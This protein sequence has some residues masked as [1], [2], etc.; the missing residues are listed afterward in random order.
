ML[1]LRHSRPVLLAAVL[2]L[3]ACGSKD[4]DH[5]PLA[6][7]PADTPFV[8][9]NSAA[10]PDATIDAW[11]RQ[12]QGMWPV[13]IGM[14]EK[15][16]DDLA[17]GDAPEAVQARSVVRAILDEIRQRDTPAKWAEIGFSPKA[18]AAFYGVG[19]VPVLRAELGDP[20]A[21][22]AM[23]T[24]VET[25]AGATLGSSRVG[26]QELRTFAIGETEGIIALQDKHLV[27]SVLP[28][29][30]DETLKRAVLGLDRPARNLGEGGEL[31]ALEKAEKFT[32]YG[33]GWID[34]RRIVALVDNDPGYAA[35]AR[36]LDQPPGR[37]DAECRSEVDGIVAQAPRMVFGYTALEP[38]HMAFSSRLDLAPALA[39]SLMKLSTPP[40][41]SAAPA[42][43]LYDLSLSMPVLKI[44]DFLVERV[45]A[46]IAAP[47]RCPAL[48]TWNE[49][50]NELKA[51]LGQ[52]V[53]PP[54]S[55]FTGLRVTIDRLAFPADGAP[56]FSGN[57]LV[58]TANPMAIIGMAQLAVPALKDFAITPDG[59]PVALPAGVIPNEVGFAPQVHVAV[60][61]D[62]LAIGSGPDSNLSAYLAAPAASDGQLLRTA[63]SGKFYDT[64]ATM[65]TRFSSMLPEKE[66]ASID[67]QQALYAMYSRWFDTIDLRVNATPRGLEMHQV[68]ELNP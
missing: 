25:A 31:P 17:A 46:V 38:S 64:I 23:I 59:Q 63:Y 33:S 56:D 67:Q 8:V 60:D 9:A 2:A 55:D 22:R 27:L 29:D 61:A 18:R 49:S 58:A 50:A 66:R 1:N 12:M 51:R 68:V 47:F 21:F 39:Q 48:Q 14:Y 45:D 44:K 11:A 54:I 3:S 28:K 26:E 15:M 5:A 57:V 19:L 20:D 41:G 24:R 13:L 53:P 4:D 62:A 32:P 16:L 43:S 7:V 34:L 30:A 52:F 65:M 40:P 37:F 42:G 36:L 10:I 35:F 6:F